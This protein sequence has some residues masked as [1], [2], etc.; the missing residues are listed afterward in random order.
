MRNGFCPEHPSS[1][2][3]P[4]LHVKEFSIE[5]CTF[6][7]VVIFVKLDW[8]CAVSENFPQKLLILKS[9]VVILTF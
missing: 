2:K 5:S 7:E 6:A 4:S 1:G 3:P 9:F 8:S